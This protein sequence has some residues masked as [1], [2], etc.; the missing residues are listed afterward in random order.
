M[1]VGVRCATGHVGGCD[2]PLCVGVCLFTFWC[3]YRIE[4]YDAIT[5]E[6]APSSDGA[7]LQGQGAWSQH[8]PFAT[9]ILHLI[10]PLV[11]FAQNHYCMANSEELTTHFQG[12]TATPVQP[13]HFQNKMAPAHRQWSPF[14]MATGEVEV[15]L[16]VKQQDDFA[17]HKV[18][19]PALLWLP[20][21]H[22]RVTLILN[23]PS[24]S[25]KVSAVPCTC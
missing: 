7:E 19:W 13:F 24:C 2:M 22:L 6:E 17:G 10:D 16:K 9:K 1:C 25:W 11:E 5:E 21:D 18:S 12:I 3:C 14:A 20:C 4:F 8:R 15:K 23:L